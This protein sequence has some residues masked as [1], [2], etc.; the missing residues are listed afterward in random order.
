MKKPR[1]TL[2]ILSLGAARTTQTLPLGAA[3][4][5]SAVKSCGDLS[6]AWN[7]V[8]LSGYC[9]E[10]NESIIRRIRDADPR[11][12]GFSIYVWNVSKCID[13]ARLIKKESPHVRLLAGGA[14]V[15]ARPGDFAKMGLF[16]FVVRGEGENALIELL[17]QYRESPAENEKTRLNIPG[18]YEPG[19]E[20]DLPHTA[21]IDLESISSPYL[22]GTIDIHSYDGL[23]WEAARG[24]P[25]RCGFCYESGTARKARKIPMDR[26]E[27]ELELFVRDGADLVAVLDPTFNSDTERAIRILKLINR[28]A[29]GLRFTFEVRAEL[30][31]PIQVR[32]FSKLNCSIQI[33]IQSTNPKALAVTNRT[34]DEK[35]FKQKIGLLNRNGVSFGFDLIVGI[36]G[37]TLAGFKRSLDFALALEPNHLDIFPLMVLPGTALRENAA[38]LGLVYDPA[39]PYFSI[40][41]PSF[42]ANDR[43]TAARLVRACN[44][45]YT[46]GRAVAW[47]L[48]VTK[49]LKQKPSELLASFYEW[50]MS[51]HRLPGEEEPDS[52]L[53]EGLQLD[54]IRDQYRTHN[55]AKLLPA[56]ES[57]VKLHA[58]Y[59]RANIEGRSTAIELDYD[60]DDLF[61]P[62]ILD[63]AKFSTV[64][65][66][67]KAKVRVW[68][69]DGEV[70]FEPVSR[71]KQ[72]R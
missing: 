1:N 25:F 33:G 10:S 21:A 7:P 34:F 60:P 46:W 17:K 45:M 70:R 52:D 49:P 36:P 23:L 55:I 19:L 58:A 71:R 69:A 12:L 57:L 24:C 35:L 63:L 44:L 8:L 20:P 2:A 15:T 72:H 29:P 26:L 41:S 31:D 37:D 68:F 32:L 56:A 47:F 38:S 40:S 65:K 14:E 51:S 50:M 53:L 62:M 5:V 4:L 22:D 48:P 42:D 28:K 67:R 61:D 43:E 9:F 6:E 13:L 64:A 11:L 59:G 3:C 54:F 16:D 18:V 27:R 30:L 66:K 39:P